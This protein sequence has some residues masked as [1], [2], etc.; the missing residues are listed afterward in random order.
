M[1]FQQ[2]PTS[3]VELLRRA[4]VDRLDYVDDNQEEHNSHDCDVIHVYQL[5]RT[6]DQATLA[7]N[8]L[9]TRLM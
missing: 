9:I 5:D 3:V 7:S 4:V 6:I 8:R 1:V 2:D